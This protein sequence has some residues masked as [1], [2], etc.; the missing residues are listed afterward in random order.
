M[1]FSLIKIIQI[2]NDR[3][4]HRSALKSTLKIRL[5]GGKNICKMHQG[6]ARAVTNKKNA[7]LEMSVADVLNLSTVKTSSVL[8]GQLPPKLNS[9]TLQ[10][11]TVKLLI[12]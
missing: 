8:F 2:A 9:R 12:F 3:R 4:K 5:F 10:S 6:T 11:F 1:G 7:I